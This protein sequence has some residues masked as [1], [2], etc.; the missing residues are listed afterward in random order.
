MDIYK[1]LEEMEQSIRE[2]REFKWPFKGL[3]MIKRDDFL[4]TLEKA[5]ESLPEEI[6][7]ARW[8]ARENQRIRDEAVNKAEKVE[9][10]AQDRARE[11]FRTA[12]EESHRLVQESEIVTRA[13]AEAAR[14]M[15]EV[16]TRA[17]AREVEAEANARRIRE[18]ADAYSSRT[19]KEAEAYVLR[20][21]NGM[22]GELSRILSIIQRGRENLSNGAPAAPE[23]ARPTQEVPAASREAPRGRPTR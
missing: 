15:N 11:I 16:E 6:K 2:S 21:L 19:R 18:E 23:A 22:E 4:Q 8:V 13:R 1:A 7:Q 20:I 17:K 12:Q 3:S 5:R 9:S 14:I 10:Q